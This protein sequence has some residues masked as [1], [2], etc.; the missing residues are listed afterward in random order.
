MGDGNRKTY[1]SKEDKTQSI[2]RLVLVTNF[3][4]HVMAHDLWKVCNDYGV[5]VDAFIL[6]NKSKAEYKPSAPSQPSNANERNSLGSFVLMLKLG[7]MNNV[8]S[9]QCMTQSLT[10]EL[11]TP[12]EEPKQVFH[13]TRKLFKTP[14][15]DYSSSLEFDLFFDHED[16]SKEDQVNLDYSSMNV[17][18]SVILEDSLPPKKKD[19]GRL[20]DLT[21]TKLIIELADKTIKHPKGITEN[22]LIGIDKFVF[23]V[24]FVVL[25]IPEDIKVSF[26]PVRPFFATAHPK[27]DV[28]KR[29]ITLK[30]G[31][32]KVM[33]KSDKLASNIIKRVYEL[34]LRERMELDLK[35]RLMGEIKWE[36][37]GLTIEDGEVIDEPMIKE[38]KTRNDDDEISNGMDEYPSFC[39]VNRKIHI[40]FAYNL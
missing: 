19:L 2:S 18:D 24:D 1:R 31:N 12:F 38:T 3:L 40:D 29:K 4:D 25:D 23:P 13:S 5:V 36:D 7:K 9:D 39:D 15:L 32:D 11:F 16:Q 20:D 27:I 30:V 8:M 35:A 34:G 26:I 14:S 21:P 10:K 37:L 6:Y 22:I 28:L 17:H 33:S